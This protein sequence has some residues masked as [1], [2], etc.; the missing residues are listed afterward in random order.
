MARNQM[1]FGH[2]RLDLTPFL[3]KTVKNLDNLILI[4]LP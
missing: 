4:S 2:F 3:V 1:I